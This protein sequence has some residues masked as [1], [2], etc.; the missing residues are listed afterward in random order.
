MSQENVELFRRFIEVCNR[1]DLEGAIAL[2]DPPPEFESVPSVDFPRDL[3]DVQRGAE[4]FR[5]LVE[6]FW[7][8]FD[9]PHIEV[10]ELID[11]GDQVVVWATFR[12]RGKLSGTET[13]WASLWGVWTARDGRV[14]RWQG[15]TDRDAA[16]EAVGL[17]E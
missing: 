12:G 11:A 13:S 16:L 15:F 14:V 2:A 6:G 9:D 8:E 1:G 3:A 5:Q 10:H 4:G 7:A 17:R